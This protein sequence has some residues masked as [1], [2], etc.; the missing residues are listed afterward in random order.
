MLVAGFVAGLLLVFLPVG[1]AAAAGGAQYR[2]TEYRYRSEA[3]DWIG[4]GAS[5]VLSD[6]AQLILLDSTARDVRLYDSGWNLQFKAPTGEVLTRGVY[7]HA[8]RAAFVSGRAP[9]LEVTVTGRGCNEI[10][11][12]F[13]VDRLNTDADGNIT[14][15]D[16]RFAQRCDG[17]D[18]PVLHG[19]VRYRS[20]PLSYT[21]RSDPGDPF[22]G[23]TRGRYESAT[24]IFRYHQ[25]GNAVEIVVSGERDDYSILLQPPT[26]TVLSEGSY[27]DDTPDALA[28]ALHPAIYVTGNGL[29]CNESTGSFDVS[30]IRFTSSGAVRRLSATFEQHCDGADPALHGQLHFHA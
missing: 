24:S 2:V 30:V 5:E 16:I 17:A 10:F 18:A 1:A 19:W 21:Y 27:V 8:E 9:G 25:F 22:A 29:A 7:P 13:A 4:Q 20:T 11:G 26:G 15:L 12:R 28:D 6:P 14:A 23:G 3:G